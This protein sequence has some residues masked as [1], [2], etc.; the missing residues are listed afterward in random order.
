MDS[1]ATQL[2]N[3]LQSVAI[4]LM[5]VGCADT[6]KEAVVLVHYPD[7]VQGSLR[8]RYEVDRVEAVFHALE[9]ATDMRIREEQARTYDE[10]MERLQGPDRPEF[11]VIASPNLAIMGEDQGYISVMPVLPPYRAYVVTRAD[12]PAKHLADLASQPQRLTVAVKEPGSTSGFL[13]MFFALHEHEVPPES[14]DV[15]ATGTYGGVLEAIRANAANVGSVAHTQLNS[16]QHQADFRIVWASPLLPSGALLI[17]PEALNATAIS[18]EQLQSRLREY[19]RR[20]GSLGPLDFEHPPVGRAVVDQLRTGADA[21]IDAWK[22]SGAASE[23]I[24]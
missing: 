21:W 11:A 14:V 9:K 10:I 24:P 13:S 7:E 17:T 4:L 5:G 23:S 18:I 19:R 2:M 20:D 16:Y 22:T 1:E 12:S 15:T 3:A 6:R 8:D